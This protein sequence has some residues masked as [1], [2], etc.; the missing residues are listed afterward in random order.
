MNNCGIHIFVNVLVNGCSG[1]ITARGMSVCVR[2][3][4]VYFYRCINR[5]GQKQ[6]EGDYAASPGLYSAAGTMLALRPRKHVR[7][8]ALRLCLI[9]ILPNS[10]FLPLA[11][12]SPLAAFLPRRVQSAL[13]S[14]PLNAPAGS[15]N[16]WLSCGHPSIKMSKAPARA[17]LQFFTL[18]PCTCIHFVIRVLLV[19]WLLLLPHRNRL[20]LYPYPSAALCISFTHSLHYIYSVWFLG[21]SIVY[22][23]TTLHSFW[24]RLIMQ[25]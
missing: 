17:H 21:M 7:A 3:L 16:M 8:R 12:S 22:I 2:A 10:P 5:G 23:S 13:Q 1:D 24:L 4:C 25:L 20:F 19:D 9:V 18:Y 14:A 11:L 15:S 6:L